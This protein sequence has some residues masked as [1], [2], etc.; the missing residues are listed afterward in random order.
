MS[1]PP[2]AKTKKLFFCYVKPGCPYSTEAVKLLT[3]NKFPPPKYTE[4]HPLGSI[5]ELRKYVAGDDEKKDVKFPQ[6]YLKGKHRIGGADELVK[7]FQR[8][9]QAV[10][11]DSSSES[12]S[13]S[14]SGSDE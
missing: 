4:V 3:S 6:V 14:D 12:V 2:H 10:D 8:Y 13:G 9:N 7:F 5:E 1:L 11:D